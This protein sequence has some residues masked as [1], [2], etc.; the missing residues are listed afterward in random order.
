MEVEKATKYRRGQEGVDG[1]H[2]VKFVRRLLRNGR[3]G[4][5]ITGKKSCTTAFA[6]GWERGWCRAV[7]RSLSR[8]I[9]QNVFKWQE[10]KYC[11]GV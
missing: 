9:D 5:K 6:F 10:K 7:F 2:R 4:F 8:E 3:A 1:K 11:Q